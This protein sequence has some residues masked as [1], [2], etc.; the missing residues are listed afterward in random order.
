MRKERIKSLLTLVGADT[1]ESTVSIVDS[2]LEFIPTNYLKHFLEYV[3]K[4]Y[5]KH[6][7]PIVNITSVGQE[8][9]KRLQI[10]MIHKG[11]MRLKTVEETK[12]FIF[13]FFKGQEICNCVDGLYQSFVT[14]GLDENEQFINKYSFKKLDSL[15][16]SDFIYWC[17]LNQAR[18]GDVKLIPSET[19]KKL[20]LQ[21]Q[22][23][24][25]Q[26]KNELAQEPVNNNFD[27][28]NPNV[29][30]IASVKSF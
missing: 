11:E 2:L 6:K 1:S 8:Y 16:V 7:K 13:E 12:E 15:E 27:K 23:R 24:I 10:A 18:I 4:N 19:V 29:L 22:N 5:D 9:K 28:V 17:F 14:I 25:E 21:N 26:L 20:M 3:L 30:A